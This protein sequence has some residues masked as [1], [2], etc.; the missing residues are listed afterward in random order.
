MLCDRDER[1]A[2]LVEQLHHLREVEER[3]GQAIDL[4]DHNAVDPACCNVGK[5][6]L[7]G[8]S[9]DVA[10]RET[11]IIVAVGQDCPAFVFLRCDVCFGSFPL[12]VEV[13]NDSRGSAN[14]LEV[15]IVIPGDEPIQLVRGTLT[16]KVYSLA[17]GEST[18][19]DIKLKPSEE[20]TFNLKVLIT[21]N[22]A[23]GK[24]I[25]PIENTVPLEIKI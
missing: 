1:Y 22:D 7:Q 21:F 9:L 13:S 24:A 8:R 5:E 15:N 16:K 17:A 25:G 19:W 6:P 10:A 4:V 23:D 3:T 14:N 2:V 18:A 11:A 12:R 20:R